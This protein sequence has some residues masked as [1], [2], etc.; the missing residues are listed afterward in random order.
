MQW[1]RTSKTPKLCWPSDKQYS[2]TVNLSPLLDN[3]FGPCFFQ[4]EHRKS[5]NQ[6]WQGHYSKQ[7]MEHF[8]AGNKKNN[9][10]LNAASCWGLDLRGAI[11]P[12]L[13][14]RFTSSRCNL[15]FIYSRL[16]SVVVYLTIAQWQ[17]V[18]LQWKKTCL[19]DAFYMTLRRAFSVQVIHTLNIQHT[20]SV[21]S[22]GETNDNQKYLKHCQK[23][24]YKKTTYMFM[25][26]YCPL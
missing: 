3:P 7:E 26:F 9:Q 10:T 12:T 16:R 24:S 2:K 18:H 23:L 15:F 19:S 1:S 17:E 11:T 20:V 6:S 5:W 25:F 14:S 13:H 4:L 21:K 22:S 8:H